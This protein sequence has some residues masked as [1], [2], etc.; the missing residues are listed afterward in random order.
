[1]FG[2][3]KDRYREPSFS[4]TSLF[5][6]TSFI[7]LVSWGEINPFL[8]LFIKETLH[9]GTAATSWFTSLCIAAPY[10]VGMLIAPVWNRLAIKYGAKPWLL[11]AGF[12]SAIILLLMSM[13]QNPLQLVILKI[14]QGL[15]VG[16]IS[17]ASSILISLVPAAK[18]GQTLGKLGVATSLATVL[19]PVIGGILI[20][21]LSFRLTLIISGGLLLLCCGFLQF[22]LPNTRVTPRSNQKIPRHFPV[23]LVLVLLGVLLIQ[24]TNNSITP[25]LALIVRQI[26]SHAGLLLIGVT[27][28]ITG[29]FSFAISHSVDFFIN[30]WSS[31]GLLA[32]ALLLG[33]MS[34]VV[35]A[36]SITV[37]ALILSRSLLGLSDAGHNPTIEIEVS[38]TIPH[39][40]LG[41]AFA[42]LQFVQSFGVVIGAFAGAFLNNSGGYRTMFTW[43]AIGYFVSLVVVLTSHLFPANLAS[44]NGKINS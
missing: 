5:V 4:I 36:L 9:T 22:R 39:S 1:M 21:L 42:L 30:R 3:F 20:P 15:F 14:I 13:V 16:F 27:I 19:A 43:A 24:I 10:L 6:F 2:F 7:F 35:A 17:I 33:T 18:V 37:L 41:S 28:A 11:R 34:Y 44:E 38:K 12:G 32:F 31:I 23:R 25:Y 29:V 40:Q 8:P 26:D